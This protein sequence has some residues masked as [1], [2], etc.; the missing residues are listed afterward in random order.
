MFS[1]TCFY[2]HVHVYVYVLSLDCFPFVLGKL[3]SS[4]GA[5]RNVIIWSD[6]FVGQ[7]KYSYVHI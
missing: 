5:D 4:G 1:S 3:F 6:A 2:S 7:L